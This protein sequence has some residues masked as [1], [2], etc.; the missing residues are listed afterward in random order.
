MTQNVSILTLSLAVTAAI[1]AERFV[2][3]SGAPATA[4][5]NAVGVARS[6]GA[7]GAL[8]PV[9]VLGTAVVTAGAAI[10]AGAAIEVGATG[11][12]VTKAAGIAV[13][14]ALQAAAADGERIEVMLIPN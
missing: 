4:A 3:L 8:V 6:D 7:I 10:A 11:K 5:G 13:A 12:A 1:T 14:R 9:D 2:D